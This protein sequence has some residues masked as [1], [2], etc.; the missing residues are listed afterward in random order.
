MT[1]TIQDLSAKM[2][3][4]IQA[5]LE[6]NEDA[7]IKQGNNFIEKKIIRLAFPFFLERVPELTKDLVSMVSDELGLLNVNDL[8]SF[9]NDHMKQYGLGE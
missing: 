2:A 5:Y 4:R 8:L 7:F 9:L 1:T 6:A 3:P